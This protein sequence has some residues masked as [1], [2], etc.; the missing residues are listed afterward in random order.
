MNGRGM[1]LVGGVVVGAVTVTAVT[2]LAVKAAVET[3][4]AMD[5][6]I[7]LAWETAGEVSAAV[8]NMIEGH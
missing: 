1:I 6:A 4:K 7:D 8:A 2:A 5:A 3:A